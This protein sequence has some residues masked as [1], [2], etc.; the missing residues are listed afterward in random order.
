MKIQQFFYGS[1]NL[2]YLLH[3]GGRALAIDGGAVEA[4]LDYVRDRDLVLIG[5]T[6]THGHGDHTSGTDRLVAASGAPYRDHRQFDDGE[7]IDLAGETITVRHTPGHTMDSVTFCA[8]D[9][10]VTGDT[11]FNGTVGNCF[12]GDLEAFYRSIRLLMD[13]PEST[14]IYA[15]H[16]YVA[17]S[18]AFARHLT[19][20]NRA[21]DAY[22]ARY[23]KHHVVS[24]LADELAVNP[25][26]R[27]NQPDIIALLQSR[28][29]PTE[30]EYQR[31]EGVMSLE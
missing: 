8:G 27:F 30:T 31:W 7:V 13:R 29:R 10:M 21:I 17:A 22:A 4:I 9:V 1:D 15:G 2:A 12:S 18:L 19:P 23:D 6:N 20:D 14:R 26:L 5:V 24:T 25:Y 11:L 3:H 16:D 28:G